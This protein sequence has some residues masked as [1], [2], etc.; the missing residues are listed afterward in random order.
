MQEGR[1]GM[2]EEEGGPTERKGLDGG[3]DRDGEWREG[4]KGSKEEYRQGGGRIHYRKQCT[5]QA[6]S[7]ILM[8]NQGWMLY[9]RFLSINKNTS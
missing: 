7:I 9:V 6:P 1:R 5:T 3:R 8:L 2:E 4:M